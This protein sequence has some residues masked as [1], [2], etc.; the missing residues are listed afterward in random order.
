MDGIAFID[1][2]FPSGKGTCK[3][4]C[5]PTCHPGQID[6]NDWHYGC[7]HPAWPQNKV[8]DFCPFVKC[9]GDIS[10]CEIPIRFLSALRNGAWRRFRNAQSKAKRAGDDYV[11][12]DALINKIRETRKTKP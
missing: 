3:H 2:D 12:L 6:E 10:K 8:H 7:L 9:A 11:E 4:H 5:S 1:G